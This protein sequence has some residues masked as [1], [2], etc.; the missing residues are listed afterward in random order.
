MTDSRVAHFWRSMVGQSGN[1]L[2]EFAVKPGTCFL[3]SRCLLR[4]L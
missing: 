2:Y 1:Y 4:Q 3:R